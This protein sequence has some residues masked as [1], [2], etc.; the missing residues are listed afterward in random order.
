M[1]VR[2]SLPQDIDPIV[3]NIIPDDLEKL[4]G[5]GLSGSSVRDILTHIMLSGV[6][7][8]VS[9]DSGV[10]GFA[11]GLMD[12]L[13]TCALPQG[14]TIMYVPLWIIETTALPDLEEAF[15]GEFGN[16][17]DKLYKKTMGLPLAFTANPKKS[18]RVRY[19]KELGFTYVK[20]I[21]E[22]ERNLELYVIKPENTA[23]SATL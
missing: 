3:K 7:Y 20:Q 19:L 4:C 1:I 18:N 9:S 23:K 6:S 12:T 11:Y 21:P 14:K 8:T 13:K 17:I 15:F 5:T 10:I 2:N 16:S 22:N